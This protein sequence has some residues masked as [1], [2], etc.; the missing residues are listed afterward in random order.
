MTGEQFVF[1]KAD[2]QLYC[3]AHHLVPLGAGGADSPYNLIVVSPLIHRMFHYAEVSGLDLSKIV[4]NKL[5]ITING[6]TYTITWNPLHA[7]VVIADAENALPT[8]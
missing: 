7:A 3:E 8:K 4:D 1:K 5:P 6:E 2:G